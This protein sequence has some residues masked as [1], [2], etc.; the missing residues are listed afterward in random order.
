MSQALALMFPGS[1]K[2]AELAPMPT[3]SDHRGWYYGYAA[4]LIQSPSKICRI[5]TA[6]VAKTKSS[7]EV[8]DKK[9]CLVDI[10]AGGP[11]AAQP[12]PMILPAE[13]RMSG[14]IA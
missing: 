1:P 11:M 2:E 8:T 9:R 10:C 3:G 7:R 12:R 6:Q 13:E 5:V 4:M 14:G